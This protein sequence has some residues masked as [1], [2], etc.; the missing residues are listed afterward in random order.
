MDGTK[1][2]ADGKPK[3]HIQAVDLG[4]T[5]PWSLPPTYHRESDLRHTP[6]PAR[7]DSLEPTNPLLGIATQPRTTPSATSITKQAT[8]LLGVAKAH[9][10]PSKGRRIG[11]VPTPLASPITQ[12]GGE[13]DDEIEVD[14][15]DGN[16]DVYMFNAH[17]A[18]WSRPL[19]AGSVVGAPDEIPE[20][21]KLAIENLK[22]AQLNAEQAK[23]DSLADVLLRS[24][25]CNVKER[26]RR[27]GALT[28]ERLGAVDVKITC[29]H[30][31]C[32]APERKIPVGAYYVGA[33]Q[34]TQSEHMDCY[35]L[36]CLEDMW[37]GKGMQRPLEA[38]NVADEAVRETSTSSLDGL[39]LGLDGTL[40][41]MSLGDR[42]NSAEM[43]ATTPGSC[44]TGST[45]EIM[46]TPTTRYTSTAPPSPPRRMSE[47]EHGS[48]AA[49]VASPMVRVQLAKKHGVD[50]AEAVA[51][52]S[53]LRR[54]RDEL[55]SRELCDLRTGFGE[56]FLDGQAQ[57]AVAESRDCSIAVTRKSARLQPVAQIQP[58]GL[59]TKRIVPRTSSGQKARPV[60]AESIGIAAAKEEQRVGKLYRQRELAVAKL[61]P[62]ESATLRCHSRR[63]TSGGPTVALDMFGV[64]HTDLV[65]AY[66]K[67]YVKSV[68]EDYQRVIAVPG[69]SLIGPVPKRLRD[70]IERGD[71]NRIS[72]VGSKAEADD[73][74]SM[75]S[76]MPTYTGASEYMRLLFAAHNGGQPP[77]DYQLCDTQLDGTSDDPHLPPQYDGTPVARKPSPLSQ[78]F[79]PDSLLS[80]RHAPPIEELQ[81]AATPEPLDDEEL[82]PE[83]PGGPYSP[84]STTST[85]Q[86]KKAPTRLQHVAA[87]FQAGETLDS[88]ERAAMEL[89]KMASAEQLSWERHVARA[90]ELREHYTE[91]F[92]ESQDQKEPSEADETTS[93]G[94]GDIVE[95]TADRAAE[96]AK[97]QSSG[98]V[99]QEAPRHLEEKTADDQEG[100]EARTGLMK[101]D[102]RG[103]DL[104]GVLAELRM[105]EA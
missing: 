17:E 37:S 3:A 101:D 82:Y 96:D 28:L 38:P 18:S 44:S 61:K 8:A 69:S 4:A 105:R 95:S 26:L 16:D 51:S 56:A 25:I 45:A 94:S 12:D 65:A 104:S 80:S 36:F 76:P 40:D 46:H 86:W 92:E 52:S 68:S 64:P 97:A 59:E 93:I 66:T 75:T 23:L 41:Y 83:T 99:P 31:L 22:L 47:D 63:K 60:S 24:V 55:I 102:C 98:R 33:G 100:L 85:G 73:V 6:L 71:V 89:W 30:P 50:H 81:R 70:A 62:G 79:V 32:L 43:E 9:S 19:D 13:S 29:A 15:D 53:A 39:A 67:Y 35:C 87:Y 103:K 42:T 10:H 2:R 49:G 74:A 57:A 54:A 90:Q 84:S 1:R 34:S 20:I 21:A 14:T 27:G 78:S 5:P 48:L 7:K 58:M 11:H 91:V 88:K 77:S 72:E